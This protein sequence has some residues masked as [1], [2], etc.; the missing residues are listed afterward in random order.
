M[1]SITCP[2]AGAWRA[3]LDGERADP[4]VEAHLQRC[5]ACQAEVELLRQNASHAAA[6][7]ELLRVPDTL[8]IAGARQ[9]LSQPRV[10]VAAR[11]GW[12]AWPTRLSTGWRVAAS[13]LAAAVVLSVGLAASPDGRA[14]A[15]Q[16]LAQFRSQQVTPIAITPQSQAEIQRTI[17]QL[18]NY[19]LVKAP[20]Y[21]RTGRS[22]SQNTVG[23]VAEASQR[24]GF[25]L[26]TP[27]AAS[28]PQGLSPTPRIQVIP[29]DEVRFTFDAAKARAYFQATGH[30]EVNLPERFDGTA[31]V[32][33]MPPAALFQYGQGGSRAALVIGQAGELQ[34]GVDSPRN[35]SLEE[36]RDF[37]LGLPGIPA[38]TAAQ[39]RSITDWR[40]TLPIPVPTD[41]VNWK[42][43]SF[44]GHQGLLLD[45]N[46]GAA[47]AAVWQADGH[48]YGLAGPLKATD[49]QRVAAS[50][51]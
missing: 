37:L 34:V 31:L 33:A 1:I 24:V 51:H 14:L 38:D 12:L 25:A 15:S 3:W 36:L 35:V 39:L 44:G 32:V 47:S 49:L 18:S 27:D 45:D 16:F 5:S 48:L 40:T 46:S 26:K 11:R 30:P 4:A 23:S 21:V 2:E 29:A 10:V 19:G 43:A 28:L 7:L 9:R 41:K 42:S 17:S 50:L 20:S 6:A 8:S 13:G 22:E